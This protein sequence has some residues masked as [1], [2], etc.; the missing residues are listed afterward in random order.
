[1]LPRKRKRQK[2]GI[3]EVLGI[4]RAPKVKQKDK[5][6]GEIVEG[7]EEDVLRVL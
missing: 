6:E 2:R 7:G 4:G 1:M 5:E 3:N